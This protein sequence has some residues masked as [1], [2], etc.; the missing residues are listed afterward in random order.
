MPEIVKVKTDKQH[1]HGNVTFEKTKVSQ[2][3][4]AR[5][6]ACY[7]IYD[8]NWQ[9]AEQALDSK[10]CKR[11]N[12]IEHSDG[13]ESQTDYNSF[14]AAEIERFIV[15]FACIGTNRAEAEI[16]IAAAMTELV[17]NRD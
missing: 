7:Y 8:N 5:Y 16:Q 6:L 11:R 13:A 9:H 4:E 14:L 10:F 2:L 12:T 15:W 3:L 17:H 1:G